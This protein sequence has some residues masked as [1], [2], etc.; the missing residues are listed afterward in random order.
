MKHCTYTAFIQETPCRQGAARFIKSDDWGCES[1]AAFLRDLKSNGYKVIECHISEVYDFILRTDF[2]SASE[3]KLGI[4]Y[5]TELF[6][7]NGWIDDEQFGWF[8]DGVKSARRWIREN[9][10]S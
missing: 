4:R 9:G 6:K 10:L 5:A 8:M 7:K 3:R 1:K 2:D